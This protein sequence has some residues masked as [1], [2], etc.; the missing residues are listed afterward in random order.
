[1]LKYIKIIFVILSIQSVY[2]QERLFPENLSDL[3]SS[4]NLK[5]RI[6]QAL[7]KNSLPSAEKY[8]L[9]FLWTRYQPYAYGCSSDLCA[10]YS[11]QLPD[12]K[13]PE[14]TRLE[15]QY[16]KTYSVL[17]IDPA[18]DKEPFKLSTHL[19]CPLDSND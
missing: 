10:I 14:G 2:A 18:S 5:Y 7:E 9:D 11:V 6:E 8:Q 17:Q 3:S 15:G 16:A 19:N 1:M 13:C 4:N 12:Q